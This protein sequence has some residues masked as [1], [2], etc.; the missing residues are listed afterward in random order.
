MLFNPNTEHAMTTLHIAQPVPH[1]CDPARRVW[2]VS[3]GDLRIG[4]VSEGE[5]GIFVPVRVGSCG[6]AVA[7]R[8]SASLLQAARRLKRM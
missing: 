6:N 5:G 3:R 1:A 2:N 4:Y 7:G 8:I